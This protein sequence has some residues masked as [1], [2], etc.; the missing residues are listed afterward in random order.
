MPLAENTLASALTCSQTFSVLANSTL[1]RLATDTTRALFKRGS[2]VF[3]RG[4]PAT[5]IHVVTSGQLTLC[6]NAAHG[7]E[8]VIDILGPGD[9]A[10]EAAT[11]TDRPH[12]VTASAATDSHLLHVSRA[13]ILAELDRDPAFARSIVR[14]LSDQLYR[15]TSD[16]GNVLLH[17]ATSRVARFILD[18][19]DAQD[20]KAGCHVHLTV[21]KGVIASRLNM[22]Q[23]HFSRTLRELSAQGRIAVKGGEI[24][25]TDVAGLRLL[26]A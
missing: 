17:K 26:A 20:A 14:N 22:T 6:L 18:Q 21:A 4:E 11:L 24:N 8:H 13:A 9:C 7:T 2:V 5:G 3:S 15:R 25:V 12:L 23:E 10:G 1:A 16:F 19:L